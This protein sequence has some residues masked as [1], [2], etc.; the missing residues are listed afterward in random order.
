MNKHALFI[1]L[2]SLSFSYSFAS[3]KFCENTDGLGKIK[4]HLFCQNDLSLNSCAGLYFT[5]TSLGGLAGY[6]S[7]SAA[8]SILNKDKLK[9][10]KII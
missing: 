6:G 8:N 9:N 4:S 2:F 10:F 3:E 7:Q 1:I 5:G